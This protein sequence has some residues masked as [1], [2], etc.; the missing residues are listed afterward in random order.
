[1]PETPEPSPQEILAAVEALLAI[2]PRRNIDTRER[3]RWIE[4]DA[5]KIAPESL[6]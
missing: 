1:M 3:S 4:S 6:Y 5:R 2:V